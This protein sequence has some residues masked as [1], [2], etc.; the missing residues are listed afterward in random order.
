MNPGTSEMHFV[1]ALDDVPEMRG[2]LALF[3]GVATGAADGYARIAGRPASVLLHLGPGLGNGLANLHNARKGQVP[4][5]NIVGD[6]ATYHKQ[7]DAQLESDIETVARNV[8]SWI[9]W[10][11]ST[12]D[13]GRDAAEAVAAAMGPPGQV[14]SLILPADVSWLDGGSVAP[15]VS[16]TARATVADDTISSIAKLVRSGEPIA[17]LL[18]GT[19]VRREGL[20]AASRIATATDAKLLCETF[21]AALDR[22]AGIPSVDRIGYL[23]EFAAMQLDGLRHLVLV[24]A[25]APVSFFAY[26][27][28]ESDLVPEGCEVHVLA[29]PIDDAPGA[30]VALADAVGATAD[31]VVPQIASRPERPTGDLTADKVA[32]G[33]GAL[34]PEGAIVSDEANTS[35]IFIPAVT[36]GAPPHLWMC[37]TGGA[38]GQGLPVATGAAL[39][40]PDRKVLALEADG[41]ALYTFQSLWTQA[42]EG[43]DVTTVIFNNSSYAVLNMELNR[44]G[45]SAGGP[46][47]KEMLD[48]SGPT[49]D[50]VH[51][52][53]GMGVPATRATTGEELCEQLARALDEPGPALVEAMIPGLL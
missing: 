3:E 21:P 5:V 20:E 37:L 32:A 53:R 28:K 36:A 38:I 2:V 50:F 42:R 33:I 24:D 17:L 22:G 11:R 43:L 34:L 51:L 1:A 52:A 48:L 6:H 12:E 19:A 15:P 44:I 31:D 14:A 16:P 45:A 9:R 23:A 49:P 25:K 39:A 7:Y 35:G 30:L 47:A 4:I 27:G 41:S 26:P 13:I 40:A 8:S 29:S 18:G 10:S 46:K